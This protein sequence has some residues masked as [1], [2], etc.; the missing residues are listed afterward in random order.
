[1]KEIILNPLNVTMR[2]YGRRNDNQ[3]ENDENELTDQEY[4]TKELS[5]YHLFFYS[6]LSSYPFP[7]QFYKKV[8]Q[9]VTSN[10]F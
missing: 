2:R 9:R 8:W 1:M 7:L 6:L 3:E 10:S 4:A 5:K